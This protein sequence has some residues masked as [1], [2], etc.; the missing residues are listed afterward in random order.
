MS[1][2]KQSQ[3]FQKQEFRQIEGRNPVMEAL[4]AGTEI[5]NFYIEE[6]LNRDDRVLKILKLARKRG[7]RVEKI[8]SKKLK[9]MSKTGGH[10]QGVIL[11]AELKPEQD[12]LHLLRDVLDKNETP[13][14]IVAP[15]IIYE[16]NLGAILR[17]AEASGVHAVITSN[18]GL[19]LTAV[20]SRTAVG[21][22]EYIPLIHE[23]IF[24]TLKFFKKQ[25]I[26][27]F[28]LQESENNKRI[29][30]CDF[31]VPMAIVIGS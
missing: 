10:H 21:A 25:G 9:R 4:L 16:H 23:N 5:K 7:I 30:N 15:E 3:R 27:I 19:E 14:F 2:K 18:R 20:V 28:G 6:N 29:F 13:L 31:T 24:T 26:K 12:V 8:Y 17:S 1:V 11:H 22:G